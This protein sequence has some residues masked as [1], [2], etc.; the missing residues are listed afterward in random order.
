MDE[1]VDLVVEP[2]VL[3]TR[4][5]SGPTDGPGRDSGAVDEFLPELASR[6][7]LANAY[8]D[9]DGMGDLAGTS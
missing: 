5:G 1:F 4:R 8:H 2:G 7:F 3:V 6:H 9:P